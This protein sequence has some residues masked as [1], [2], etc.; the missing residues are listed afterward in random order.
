M[1]GLLIRIRTWWETAD[2][3]QKAIT[4]FGSAFL[5]LLLVGTFYFASKP[6][7]AIAFSGLTSQEVGSVTD[8]VQK[9]GIPVEFDLAGN[10]QVPSEKVAEV[11]AK[12][13]L[14]GK[15]PTSGH[16]GNGELGK[17]GI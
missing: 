15:L 10:V 1:A 14:A 9:L 5:V 2:R 16:L 11:R 13:A 17:I 4:V 7:L 8:E 3:T 12:L 6:H